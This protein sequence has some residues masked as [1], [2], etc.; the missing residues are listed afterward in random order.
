MKC[1]KPKQVDWNDDLSI[2]ERDQWVAEIKYDGERN[3]LIVKDG[4][5]KL[6]RHEGRDK[7]SFF[8]EVVEWAKK[9]IKVDCILD[10]ESSVLLNWQKADFP[11]IANRQTDNPDKQNI[12]LKTKP[13]TF[14]AFDIVELK[15]KD[16]REESFG[17]RRKLLQSLRLPKI[18][19]FK[20][21][22]VV[23]I[24]SGVCYH[25]D[26]IKAMVKEL[27]LEGIVLKHPE[28]EN[29]YIKLKNYDEEEFEISGTNVTATGLKNGHCISALEL[30][31]KDG[32]YVGDCTYINNPQTEEFKKAVVGKKVLVRFMKTDAYRKGEGKLRF[33]VM[34]KIM[35]EYSNAN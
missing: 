4:E 5:V 24:D 21:N 2:Y 30:K 31:N 32:R 28:F 19:D 33:P 10:G 27:D 8:P 17:E 12:L 13:V 1:V 7:T 26:V 18:E 9:N 23:I 22:S 34:Q 35:E 16:V 6:Q 11:S 15:G 14:V 3:L 25:L 20:E 29:K